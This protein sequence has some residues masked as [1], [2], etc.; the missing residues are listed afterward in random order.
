MSPSLAYRWA[1]ARSLTRLEWRHR[2]ARAAS[3]R[4]TRAHTVDPIEADPS[5]VLRRLETL[6][7]DATGDLLARIRDDLRDAP[8][9]PARPHWTRLDGRDAWPD[10]PSHRIDLHRL[11][12]T[13]GDV[14]H[15]WNVGKVWHWPRLAVHGDHQ[16]LL[17]EWHDFSERCP[18]GYGVQWTPELEAAERALNWMVTLALLEDPDPEA[19]RRPIDVLLQHGAFLHKRITRWS[20][21]HCIGEMSVLAML[22]ALAPEP[23]ATA[24][25][26]RA[27][28]ALIERCETLI[29]PDGAYGERSPTYSFLVWQYLTLAL[30]SLPNHAVDRIQPRLHALGKALAALAH[31]DGTLPHLGDADDAVLLVYPPC[32]IGLQ[33]HPAWALS[34]FPDEPA[35]CRR[36]LPGYGVTRLS[37]GSTEVVFKWDNP[38]S[39]DGASPH[40][41]DD[42]LQTVVRFAGQDVL[43]DGGTFSYTEDPVLRAELRDARGHNAPIL[44]GPSSGVPLSTF[45]WRNVPRG[46]ALVPPEPAET[47][48][49]G[50]RADARATRHVVVLE[51]GLVLIVDH[52]LGASETRWRLAHAAEQTATN[53][54]RVGGHTAVIWSERAGDIQ[55]GQRPTSV[56]YGERFDAPTL[57]VHNQGGGSALLLSAGTVPARL[58]PNE[59]GELAVQRGQA[60][61]H[62]R[63]TP[64]ALSVR[65]IGANETD[66][67]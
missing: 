12:K 4:I 32:Q 37:N 64:Q 19:L 60:R 18:V 22:A 15:I 31:Q 53:A 23:V 54:W 45:R 66:L 33:D 7:G 46:E 24:W 25:R 40:V 65:S 13:C 55:V 50:R 58:S 14:R 52:V 30:P 21:N 57:E 3:D 62:I 48:A 63:H 36:H 11:A 27:V 2:I 16:R 9:D 38:P 56:C 26:A 43:L 5:E 28:E 59:D 51:E 8:A 67:V 34:S 47:I 1:Q 35:E 20:W 6:W 17:E 29:E 41:H 49:G 44:R 10:T 61:W 42:I 39:Q